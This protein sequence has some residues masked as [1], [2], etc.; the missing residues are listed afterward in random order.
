[1]SRNFVSAISHCSIEMS[2]SIG[3]RDETM[4]SYHMP[5]AMKKQPKQLPE[6]GKPGPIKAIFHARQTKQKLFSLL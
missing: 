3:T 6:T 5:A 4:V 2:D 1:M